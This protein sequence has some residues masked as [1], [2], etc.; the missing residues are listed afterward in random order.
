MT[1]RG[2]FGAGGFGWAVDTVLDAGVDEETEKSPVVEAPLGVD[3]C[4]RDFPKN[5]LKLD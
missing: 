5:E 1:L 3:S 4:V 2:G